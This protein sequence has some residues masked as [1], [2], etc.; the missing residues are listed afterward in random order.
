MPQ[1]SDHLQLQH[2]CKYLLLSA[3]ALYSVVHEH[4]HE[5]HDVKATLFIKNCYSKIFRLALAFLTAQ[6]AVHRP[7]NGSNHMALLHS[8]YLSNQD[9]PH[10]LSLSLYN[11][12]PPLLRGALG[13]AS[14]LH[15]HKV[16][17]IKMAS[18]VQYNVYCD[19]I[20]CVNIN[21]L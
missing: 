1:I 6:T 3:L 9:K 4:F 7:N 5:A 21:L 16:V 2:T 20:F 10:S 12:R 11:Q 15:Q 19:C 18:R 14:V 8:Q 13:A 17:K